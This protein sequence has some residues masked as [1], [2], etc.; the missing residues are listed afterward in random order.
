[1]VVQ[2]E[3]HFQVIQD[4]LRKL[5]RFVGLFDVGLHQREL[6]A[7]QPRQRAQSTA[8]GPQTIGQG[9]QQL[10]AYLVG[11][12]LVDALEIIQAYA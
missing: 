4:A 9:Q 6:V 7:P 11:E 8:V 2:V 12:L 5:C 3:G 10:V 1:M